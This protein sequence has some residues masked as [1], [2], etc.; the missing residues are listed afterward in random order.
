MPDI[1]LP[2]IEKVFVQPSSGFCLI[3]VKPGTNRHETTPRRAGNAVI[4]K[5]SEETPSTATLLGEVMNACGVPKGVYNVVHG[6][7]P[8]SAGEFL[9]TNQGVNAITFTGETR[10][11]AAI[12]KCRCAGRHG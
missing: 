10:T 12:M 4:V 9:T 8:N 5:P 1:H 2:V 7:G 3:V 6:F 11:G